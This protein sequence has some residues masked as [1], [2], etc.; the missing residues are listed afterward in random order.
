M[1]EFIIKNRKDVASNSIFA[2]PTTLP[3][4]LCC[5]NSFICIVDFGRRAT[6][7][8]AEKKCE[9]NEHYN[10]PFHLIT[11]GVALQSGGKEFY[12]LPLS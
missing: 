8:D 3:Y 2:L 1:F 5:C 11:S 4:L 7:G 12:K 9:K 6:D 10:P